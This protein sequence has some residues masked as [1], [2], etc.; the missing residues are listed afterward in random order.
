MIAA[1][2]NPL[3]VNTSSFITSCY[4]KLDKNNVSFKKFLDF[5]EKYTR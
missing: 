3:R 2:Q 4:D 1:T 5:I